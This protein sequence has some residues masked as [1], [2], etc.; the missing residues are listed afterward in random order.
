MEETIQ[1]YEERLTQQRTDYQT[2][3]ASTLDRLTSD[4]DAIDVK[5]EI[6]RKLLKEL[7]Q[8]LNKQ[9]HQM[10]RESAIL[11]EKL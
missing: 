10:E 6:K 2:D 8:N 9:T 7:E 1:R 5:Y 3:M 11:K 4:K